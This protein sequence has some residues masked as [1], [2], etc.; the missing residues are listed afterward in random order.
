MSCSFCKFTLY[1]FFIHGHR[2][3]FF[4]QN[5]NALLDYVEM[6]C[7]QVSKRF[8]KPP[9]WWTPPT[10]EAPPPSLRKPDLKCF[11]SRDSDSRYCVRCQEE[12]DEE[13]RQR[14]EQKKKEEEKR[15]GKVGAKMSHRERMRRKAN[16]AKAK[17]EAAKKQKLKK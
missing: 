13:E 3:Y 4:F 15:K 5:R 1:Q 12:V 7:K 9:D 14:L 16:E 6:V 2:T 17:K 11:E 10:K 8:V